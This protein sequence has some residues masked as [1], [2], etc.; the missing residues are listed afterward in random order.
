MEDVSAVKYAVVQHLPVQLQSTNMGESD[1]VLINSLYLDNHT[2]ELYHSRLEKQSGSVTLRLRWNGTGIPK[3]VSIEREIQRER[4]SSDISYSNKTGSNDLSDRFYSIRQKILVKED[5]ISSLLNGT[6]NIEKDAEQLRKEEISEAIKIATGNSTV[7]IENPSINIEEIDEKVREWKHLLGEIT[8]T[9]TSKQ[10]VPT[11]R[12]QFMR[13]QFMIPKVLNENNNNSFTATNPHISITLDTQLCMINERNYTEAP[14]NGSIS[15]NSKHKW[16]RDPTKPIPNNEIIRFPHAILEIKTMFVTSSN[17]NESIKYPDWLN[18]L[19]KS[20]KLLEVHKFSGYL[21]GCSVLLREDVRKVPYWIDEMSNSADYDER[22]N[23]IDS[24]LIEKKTVLTNS[25]Q[26]KQYLKDIQSYHDIDLSNQNIQ[27]SSS[28]S[29]F[30]FT[31]CCENNFCCLFSGDDELCDCSFL[32]AESEE[33]VNEGGNAGGALR[34]SPKVLFA[35]ERTFLHWIH[36]AVMLS[37]ISSGVLAFLPSTSKS[38]F[39]ETFA[40]F[41]LFLSLVFIMYALYNFYM[42]TNK[43]KNNYTEQWDDTLGPIL[44]TILLILFLCFQFILQI[45]KFIE[46]KN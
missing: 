28:S 15:A 33:F 14:S 32:L 30:S 13:T 16:L 26:I 5:K 6:I 35:N 40:F 4:E 41:F 12:T 20:G 27:S 25:E 36:M 7:K 31:S 34:E 3:E 22:K 1:S 39:I 42:R 2:L 18:T 45:A 10:L 43:I 24:N 38:S 37:S 21:H 9:I 44:I 23:S 46:E 29:P 8:Q 19:L 11:I 17:V